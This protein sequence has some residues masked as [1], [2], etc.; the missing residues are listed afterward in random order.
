VTDGVRR[1]QHPTRQITGHFG[2]ELF[3]LITL[4][5]ATK[6][7]SNAEWWLAGQK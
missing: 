4:V 5:A 1:V 6:L 7:A 3:Q 2:D